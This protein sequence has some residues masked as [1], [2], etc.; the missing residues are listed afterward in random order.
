M[1]L[2][3]IALPH[4]D[5]DLIYA[6]PANIT[7]RTIYTN[8]VCL[9]HADAAAAL[10]VAA[11]LAAAQG[12]RL[13]VYDAFRPVEAQWRLWE[14]F[15]DPEF[16]ADPREGSNHARGVAVDLTLADADGAPLDMGTPFDDMTALSHHGN[17]SIPALPKP[18]AAGCWASWRRRA[19]IITHR[20]GGTTNCPTR[21]DILCCG[22]RRRAV[23]SCKNFP[24]SCSNG[25]FVSQK[26]RWQGKGL[27]K[28]HGREHVPSGRFDAPRRRAGDWSYRAGSGRT[29]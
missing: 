21:S 16:I 13:R 17:T 7:G 12:C 25:L 28:A 3:E 15:P 1:A 9:L 2:L 11:E 24:K 10:R 29:R 5:I 20:N 23:T 8:M 27:G 4:V 26:R 19:G 14:A 6:T 22:M 18:T